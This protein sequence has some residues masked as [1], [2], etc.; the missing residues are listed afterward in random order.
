[1][2]NYQDQID[3]IMDTFDFEKVKQTMNALDWEWA[4]PDGSSSVPDIY[5]IKR[6]ARDYLKQAAN[7]GEGFSCGGFK[8]EIRDG[9]LDLYFIVEDSEVHTSG[10]RES[11]MEVP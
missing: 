2:T 7:S 3:L 9:C 4:S 10:Y 8:V 11:L 5:T 6:T 1:M